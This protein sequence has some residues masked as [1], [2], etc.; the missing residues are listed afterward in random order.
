MMNFLMFEHPVHFRYIPLMAISL[1]FVCSG[2]Q[3]RS[4]FAEAILL[5]L[6]KRDGITG[7]NVKSAGTVALGGEKVTEPT[8]KVASDMGIDL[9]GHQAWRVTAELLMEYD[10]ILVMERIHRDMI[11]KLCPVVD[12]RV[13]LLG[14]LAPTALDGDEIP[15]PGFKDLHAHRTCFSR[16]F[17]A[18]YVLYK[19]LLKEISAE[20]TT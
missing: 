18:V 6:I 20:K 1:L 11:L 14:A 3:C 9:S 7:I 17:E 13:S 12:G 16:I 2:N 8:L 5:H 15:D 4:P 10:R 19:G